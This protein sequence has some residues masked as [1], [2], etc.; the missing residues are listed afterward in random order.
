MADGP[1]SQ[2]GHPAIN[3]EE[4]LSKERN[5]RRGRGETTGGNV[6]RRAVLKMMALL[7]GYGK[8]SGEHCVA[9]PGEEAIRGVLQAAL[10]KSGPG[11]QSLGTNPMG[12]AY[13][14][15]LAG[16]DLEVVPASNWRPKP[17]EVEVR[18]GLRTYETEYCVMKAMTAF[19]P[20]STKWTISDKAWD[21]NPGHSLILLG[22]GASNLATRDFLGDK[23]DRKWTVIY[24]DGE[25]ELAYSMA[26]AEGYVE[27]E[28]YGELY[29]GPA[30]AIV[31]N[32]NRR[33]LKPETHGIRLQ[34]DYLLVTR[35]PRRA[36]GDDPSVLI[37]AGL[38][39]PG[40]RAAEH[41]F[42]SIDERELSYLADKIGFSGKRRMPFFQAVFRARNISSKL[43]F[44]VLAEL[45]C[46]REECPP[47][48]LKPSQR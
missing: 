28:Q 4:K 11:D 5:H 41:F 31:G 32:N 6:A 1:T 44:A 37:F 42:S 29:R 34:E 3:W 2:E 40:T 7:A 13:D 12:L 48:I 9:K 14:L 10:A 16:P 19:L 30:A 23:R 39:G 45:V 43:G 8:L 15:F 18:P 17:A 25:I 35:L 46:M 24:P 20:A 26:Q 27:R 33:I 38:H 47:V 36:A 22:S 21:T